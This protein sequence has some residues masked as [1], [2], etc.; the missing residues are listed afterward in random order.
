MRWRGVRNQDVHLGPL[1]GLAQFKGTNAFILCYFNANHA[2]SQTKNENA[3][4]SAGA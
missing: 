2:I 4:A 3:P 1:N